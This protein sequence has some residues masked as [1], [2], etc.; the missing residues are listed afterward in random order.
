MGRPF[1]RARR[2]AWCARPPLPALSDRDLLKL[3]DTELVRR[4]VGG[5]TAAFHTLTDRYAKELF[6]LA[7]SLSSS[8]SDAEDICQETLVG[9]YRGLHRFEG[10]A[11]V[12]TWLMRILMR[13]A[14]GQR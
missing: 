2:A 12:K 4:A 6:R 1:W 3:S 13:R 7:L 8:R 10:K 5:D 9:A 11:S 14:G